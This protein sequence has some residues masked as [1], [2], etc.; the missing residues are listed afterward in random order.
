M[1]YT[2]CPKVYGAKAGTVVLADAFSCILITV[3][4]RSIRPGLQGWPFL[5]K[6]AIIS[7]VSRMDGRIA[8]LPDRSVWVPKEFV[9]R[10]L[11]Q[12]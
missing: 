7:Q 2:T 11:R 8:L 12:L 1:T 9:E 4:S 5:D 6:N 10:A 3:P